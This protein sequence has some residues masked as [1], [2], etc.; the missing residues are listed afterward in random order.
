MISDRSFSLITHVVTK[1]IENRL[2]T[3]SDD[4]LIRFNGLQKSCLTAIVNSLTKAHFAN[5]VWLQIPRD[6]V[7]EAHINEPSAL[8]DFNAARIRNTNLPDGKTL[9]LTANASCDSSLDTLKD[10]EAID[11]KK[12]ESMDG[13]VDQLTRLKDSEKKRLTAIK[14]AVIDSISPEITILEDFILSVKEYYD[15][16]GRDFDEAISNSLPVL[17]LPKSKTEIAQLCQAK[18]IDMRSWRNYFEKQCS[19][20]FQYFK[21]QAPQIP[22]PTLKDRLETISKKNPDFTKTKAYSVYRGIVEEE[23][24]TFKPLLQ[25]DWKNDNLEDFL[26]EVRQPVTRGLAKKTRQFLEQQYYNLI[27]ADNLPGVDGTL[28]DYFSRLEKSEKSKNPELE[29]YNFYNAN[30]DILNQNPPLKKQWDKFLYSDKIICHDFMSGLVE[31]VSRLYAQEIFDKNLSDYRILVSIKGA[32]PRLLGRLNTDILSYFRIINRAFRAY[33]DLI[34]WRFTSSKIEPKEIPL[35]DKRNGEE[36]EKITSMKQEARSI[37]FYVGLIKKGEDL[38]NGK[39]LG[40]V[41]VQWEFPKAHIAKALPRDLEKL[42][43]SVAKLGDILFVR[44]N[45]A[46]NSKGA[47]AKLSLTLPW[48]FGTGNEGYLSYRVSGLF[49]LYSLI[50]QVIENCSRNDSTELKTVWTV[51]KERYHK[52]VNAFYT[53]GLQSQAIEHMHESYLE[54]LEKI[55]SLKTHSGYR[56]LFGL[57]CSIGVY[58]FTDIST[59]YAIVPP[60]NPLRLYALHNHF[61][62]RLNYLRALLTSSEKVRIERGS[63]FLSHLTEESPTYFDPQ[64]VIMPS[65]LSN[66]HIDDANL[67]AD[68][69]LLKPIESSMGYSLYAVASHQS[70]EQ[71]HAMG[72]SEATISALMGATQAYLDLFP[73]EKDNF[74]I[75]LPDVTTEEI[76]LELCKSL[77]QTYLKDPEKSPIVN[78]NFLVTVGG[79]APRNTETETKK[80]TR[81]Y[82]G[83]V[84]TTSISPELQDAA[85]LSSSFGSSLRVKVDLR[86]RSQKTSQIA[87]LDQL[88]TEHAEYGWQSYPLEL[89]DPKN[90][91]S[92]PELQ[93]RRYF[94]F[95][96]PEK[97]KTFLTT[98]K[99]TEVGAMYLR[100]LTKNLKNTD[101][102]P[103]NKDAPSIWLPCLSLSISDSSFVD[104]L[105]QAHDLADWVVICNSLLDKRQLQKQNIEV[106]RYKQNRYNHGMEL[107][108]SKVSSSVLSKLVEKAISPLV[109]TG[110]SANNIAEHLLADSYQVSGYIALRAARRE[111]NARELVGLSLSRYLATAY[112]AAISQKNGEKVKVVSTYLLDD[113]ASWFE[114]SSKIDNIADLLLVAVTEDSNKQLYLR[115]IITEAKFCSES[116]Q[117]TEEKTSRVQ[118]EKTVKHLANILGPEEEVSLDTKV[119]M[120]RFA[121]LILESSREHLQE[122]GEGTTEEIHIISEAVRNNK[123]KVSINGFSHVFIYDKDQKTIGKQ[124][125]PQKTTHQ[126]VN[127]RCYQISIGSKSI[128]ELLTQFHRFNGGKDLIAQWNHKLM[129][130][131]DWNPLDIQELP[132][133]LSSESHLNYEPEKVDDIDMN[134]N[135]HDLD[136]DSTEICIPC[137]SE[138][139]TTDY[140]L[141]KTRQEEDK[142]IPESDLAL[143]NSTMQEQRYAPSFE[144]Y[145][146]GL[147]DNFGYSVDR[148]RWADIATEKLITKLM[149]K[150]IRAIEISHTLTPNGCLVQ[151][152][153]DDSLTTKAIK[154][155]EE[156][157]MTTSS[158]EIIF[159]QPALGKFQ[160][161]LKCPAREPVSM[162]SIWKH[163]TVSRNSVGINLQ[164]AIGRKEEDNSIL[165]LNPITHDPHTLVAG[166][167]G[168]GKTVL[169]Q[170]LLLDIAATNPSSLMK[171]YLIDPKRSVDYFAFKQLPHLAAPQIQD[172]EEAKVLLEQLKE[173]MNRRLDLFAQVGAK[174]LDKYNRKVSKEQRLP[175]LWLIHDEFAAWMVDKDY[176]IMIDEVL[177]TLTVQARAT[178][179]YI[180]LIAQRPDKDVVPMQIRDNL[181][182]RLVLKLP[183]EASSQI[184]L[185]EK[186]AEVLLGKGHMVAKLSNVITYAQ[187]PFLDEDT[188]EL[189]QAVKLIAK[190]DKEWA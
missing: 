10:V 70:T 16:G 40:D 64:L 65:I 156:N 73:L 114:L 97:A 82:E 34:V 144:A 53:E 6:L 74:S 134:S 5:K 75:T 111:N 168:S 125:A 146:Q 93:T 170:M 151:L 38:I 109:R 66:N 159:A 139:N 106:V 78:P 71:A 136:S 51:F 120:N 76:P 48:Q 4:G 24:K 26:T 49:D 21:E 162:W 164:L 99:Q 149:Q 69:M 8:T 45:S 88:V 17:G 85:L 110:E 77:Y 83:L 15:N 23:V 161:L 33:D 131:I 108:S 158:L 105:T 55:S 59:Q 142:Q 176:A 62:M 103:T 121:D 43:N 107:V 179:I 117:S 86:P 60:W 177:K 118:L 102:A 9:A 28:E 32:W 37:Q 150:D 101:E 154:N 2:D 155:L 173:E 188:D 41:S 137:K 12:I 42:H 182:N 174:N 145:I 29:D 47:I 18:R 169:V 135:S 129:S 167:T 54:L 183:T 115:L 13:W 11:A 95:S 98:P 61:L 63:A 185:G 186:G 181:G 84:N 175:V 190:A 19:N 96:H 130:A 187:A 132:L 57:I 124:L 163:R 141:G 1:Y 50:E 178:G 152:E 7:N 44:N 52:A 122:T 72:T 20:R 14:S 123:V 133:K 30:I 58:S 22:T 165:Y 91:E 172:K 148:Q 143:D 56:K 67:N 89:Y 94:D 113:Y 81:L 180:I 153:G 35:F 80:T 189:E 166:G 126:I 31:A 90:P 68:W 184:A 3:D 138:Q 79:F 36:E 39:V 27:S 119:W 127:S 160:I 128:T 147:S 25:F 100:L 104:K 116:I 87:L 140:A 112:I 157:L 171:F 92:V 46:T